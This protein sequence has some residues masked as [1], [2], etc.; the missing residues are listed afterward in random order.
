MGVRLYLLQERQ[1]ETAPAPPAVATASLFPDPENARFLFVGPRPENE[2]VRT[3]TDTL[4]RNDTIVLSLRRQGVAEVQVAQLVRVFGQVHNCRTGLQPGDS[5]TLTLDHLGQVRHFQYLPWREPERPVVVELVN[6]RLIGRCLTLPLT[7]RTEV[8]ELRLE[9]NLYNA[10]RA[11]GEG[12]EL[13]DLLA[14]DVLGSVVDFQHDPRA[15]DRIGLVFEKLYR[16]DRFIRYGRV[17]LARY[18]GQVVSQ[19]AVFHEGPAGIRGY[20]DG[21]GKSLERTFLLYALPYR[22]ITSRFSHQRFHPVLKRTVPH[23]G[24]DYAAGVGT[25]VWA[26]S[27]GRVVHAGWKG[28]LGKAVFIEHASGYVTRYGHLSRVLV[29]KGQYVQQ[30]ALIGLVGATGRTTGPH[31]H[32]EVIRDGRHL[33]PENVN[34][35]ARGRPLEAQQFAAFEARRDSLLTTLAD[36]LRQRT[37]LASAPSSPVVGIGQ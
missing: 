18:Q 16:D 3:V 33:N 25:Q 17:L 35:G 6:G 5:Y 36:G 30:K 7:T 2:L 12:D 14:D 1:V 27:R 34:K 21:E 31:L 8:V 32:Y 15:G 13:T 26:T 9:D 20:Y 24:T 4:R 10:I 19:L 22:G 11:A 37:E 23:L 29:Q 28:A